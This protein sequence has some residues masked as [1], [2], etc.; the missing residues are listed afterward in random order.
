[1]IMTISKNICYSVV[2][3]TLTL[4]TSACTPR[5]FESSPVKIVTP[6]GEVICQ[7]YTRD[8]TDWDRAIKIPSGM[9]PE[10]AD[11]I[12]RARGLEWKTT[13]Q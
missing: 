12:C 6:K 8:I 13:G 7:L 3:G 1:M 9:S 2:L 4:S 5:N 11:G 10:T